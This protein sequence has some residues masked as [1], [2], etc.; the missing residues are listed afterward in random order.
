MTLW[1]F[2]E[3]SELYVYADDCKLFNHI[4]SM[5]DVNNLQSDL[6]LMNR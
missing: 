2:E 5:K 3:G 4:N 1:K 6:D